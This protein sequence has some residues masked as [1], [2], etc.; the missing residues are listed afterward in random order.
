MPN[1]YE[2]VDALVNGIKGTTGVLSRLIS[3]KS[4]VIIL[5]I[6]VAAVLSKL[7]FG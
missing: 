2:S 5:F 4:G 1:H 7:V 6:V 3:W